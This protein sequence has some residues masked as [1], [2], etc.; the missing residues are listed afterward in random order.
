MNILVLVVAMLLHD[1]QLGTVVV[2]VSS[3]EV[4]EQ[5]GTAYIVEWKTRYEK[6]IRSIGFA[7]GEMKLIE[8]MAI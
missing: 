8:I 6:E 7:C 4:C 5:V 1:G 3:Y 2:P